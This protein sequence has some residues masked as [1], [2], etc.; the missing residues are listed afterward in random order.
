MS[1]KGAICMGFWS[2]KNRARV[3][4]EPPAGAILDAPRRS[5]DYFLSASEAIGAAAARISG[6]LAASPLRLYQRETP[7]QGHPLDKLVSFSPGPGMNAYGFVRDME[8]ARCTQGRA[9]AWIIRSGSGAGVERLRMLDPA[10][11]TPWQARETGDLWFAA[12]LEDGKTAFIPDADMLA[13]SF[14]SA[15]RAA[16]PA[17]ILQGT[18]RYDAEIKQFSL[19][20]LEGVQDTIVINV[21]TEMGRERKKKLM[22]DILESYNASGKRALVLDAGVKADRLSGSPVDPQV[23]AVEKV[24]KTRVATLYGIPPHLLGAS[25]AIRGSAEDEMEEFMAMTILPIM[26]QWEAELDKKLLTYAMRGRGMGFRFDREALSQANLTAK[27]EKYHKAIRGGWMRPNEVRRIEGLPPD[28][29]GDELMI[30][31]DL[32]PLRV[33]VQTPELLLTGARGVT[34]EE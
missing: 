22:E 19:S 2:R 4:D 9:Y 26:A 17:D 5:A 29:N 34:N 1:M 24:T 25:E 3:R 11:V 13:L 12:T 20:Q 31:R 18:I 32:L 6:A 10:T 15:G 23:L 16:R 28:P 8:T 30:S 21:P 14:L 33:N 27:A 7:L